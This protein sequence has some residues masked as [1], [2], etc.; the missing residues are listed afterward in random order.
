MEQTVLEDKIRTL[1]FKLNYFDVDKL[2]L[3]L[4]QL[5]KKI[6]KI[7]GMPIHKKLEPTFLLV[8]R[9]DDH[10]QP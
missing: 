5:N 7:E 1:G 2:S 6:K 3:Q 10:A 4:E 9:C 8:Q